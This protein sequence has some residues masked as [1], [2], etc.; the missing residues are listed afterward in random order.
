MTIYTII[1][2]FLTFEIFR[3]IIVGNL[4]GHPVY[5]AYPLLLRFLVR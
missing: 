1:S 5:A 4:L 3:Q 2:P